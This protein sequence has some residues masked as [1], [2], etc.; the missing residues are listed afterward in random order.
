ML[1]IKTFCERS[2]RIFRFCPNYLYDW[3]N[4]TKTKKSVNQ[5]TIHNSQVFADLETFIFYGSTKRAIH[6]FQKKSSILY[7]CFESQKLWFPKSSHGIVEHLISATNCVIITLPAKACHSHSLFCV[8][9]RQ[10]SLAVKTSSWC[11]ILEEGAREKFFSPFVFN[12]PI[13]FQT[14]EEGIYS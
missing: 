8:D 2:I 9:T 12:G 14:R 6:I 5:H 13:I 11:L 1:Y 3:R 7:I 4:W 10:N